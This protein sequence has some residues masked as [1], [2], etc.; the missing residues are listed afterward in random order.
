MNAKVDF[1]KRVAVLVRPMAPASA[2]PAPTMA[3]R[4]HLEEALGERTARPWLGTLRRHEHLIAVRH[5]HQ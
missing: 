4:R 3:E 1:A 5:A 2:R